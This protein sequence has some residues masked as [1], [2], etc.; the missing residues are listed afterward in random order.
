MTEFTSLASETLNLCWSRYSQ[1][2]L[3]IKA[4]CVV[5]YWLDLGMLWIERSWSIFTFWKWLFPD[6]FRLQPRAPAPSS[7][8]SART[9]CASTS[10]TP[11]ATASTT[12]P[13]S[14]TRLPV[15]GRVISIF[16][17]C[18]AAKG[19]SNI[20]TVT[21]TDNKSAAHWAVC[22]KEPQALTPLFIS[23]FFESCSCHLWRLCF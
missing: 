18:K 9:R 1:P 16:T 3:A 10:W 19:G 20:V 22:W 12:A 5:C 23:F 8:T 6:L 17:L 15:V 4:D 13:T 14:R 7:P 2:A 11:N 21:Q